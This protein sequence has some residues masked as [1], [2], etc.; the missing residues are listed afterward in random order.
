MDK[1]FNVL[2]NEAKHKNMYSNNVKFIGMPQIT[3]LSYREH[4]DLF[5]SQNIRIIFTT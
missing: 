2:K 1:Y 4:N 3:F 5:C